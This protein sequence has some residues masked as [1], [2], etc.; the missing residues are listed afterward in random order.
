MSF[1]NYWV[2]SVIDLV[3][4]NVDDLNYTIVLVLKLLKDG[5]ITIPSGSV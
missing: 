3:N 2:D 5:E 4:K 1:N